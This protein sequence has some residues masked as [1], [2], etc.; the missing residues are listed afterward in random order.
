M[1]NNLTQE[2]ISPFASYFKQFLSYMPNPD[3][4]LETTNETL[5]IY[6]VMLLDARISSLLELRKSLV[7]GANI[8]VKPVDSSAKSKK[9]AG[10]VKE[11]LDELNLYG[12]LKELLS[13]LEFGFSVVRLC[14]SLTVA[15]GG[16]RRSIQGDRSALRSNP[17]ER[18]SW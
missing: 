14:G 10:F 12:E 13:A 8:E 18:L 17:M 15:S 2:I 1:A 16:Q 6:R 4:L 9:I 3:L 7:L 5:E 11:C